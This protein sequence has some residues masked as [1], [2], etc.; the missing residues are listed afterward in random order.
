MRGYE[1]QDIYKRIIDQFNLQF[2]GKRVLDVGCGRGEMLSHALSEGA[3][4]V[5][6]CDISPAAIA[7]S[8]DRLQSRGFDNSMYDLVILKDDDCLK[9]VD[10]AFDIILMIDFVEHI[11]PDTLH[12]FL[13]SARRLL[14]PQG[15]SLL[16]H[17]FPNL[18]WH[19]ILMFILTVFRREARRE[20]E[21]IHVNVQTPSMLKQA[22]HRAGFTKYNIW[23]AS[24]F[25]FSS[26]F[27]KNMKDGLLKRLSKLLFNDIFA[28]R[29][30][31]WMTHL[32][33]IEQVVFMSI[34]GKV[35]K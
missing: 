14:S 17:T 22:F 30:V 31:R 25:I 8:R 2:S 15:G 3:S 16:I 29:I 10:G 27:Y 19:K 33:G 9:S 11:S 5:V 6:G 28:T 12:E 13:V 32:L 1:T 18:F 20:I 35:V 34:Y 7:L 21:S 26:S 24:D 23:V 4:H